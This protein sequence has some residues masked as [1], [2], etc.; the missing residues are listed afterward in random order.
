MARAT[1]KRTVRKA[2]NLRA[3]MSLP[4]VQLWQHLRRKP[5]G[6]KFR[7]QHPVGPFVVDFY[8][9]SAKLVVEIDGIA[10]DMGNRP[11]RDASRDAF[12]TERGL[13]VI[14]IPAGEVLENAEHVADSI[15][16]ACA[17]P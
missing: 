10:H 17:A 15:I 12:L 13:R 6:L 7:R 2:R 8:C 11:Q 16:A 4:E 1:S 9:A 3:A 5:Q 14:R